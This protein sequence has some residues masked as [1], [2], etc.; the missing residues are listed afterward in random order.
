[1]KYSPSRLKKAIRRFLSTDDRA[2][3][4]TGRYWIMREDTYNPEPYQVAGQAGDI[5]LVLCGTDP[6]SVPWEVNIGAI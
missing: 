6:G 2:D 5:I 3:C 1:V 4:Y